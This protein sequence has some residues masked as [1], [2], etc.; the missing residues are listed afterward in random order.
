M[1]N[2][3]HPYSYAKPAITPGAGAATGEC[4]PKQVPRPGD[5]PDPGA[6]RIIDAIGEYLGS[7]RDPL[8]IVGGL[9]HVFVAAE[10]AWDAAVD[11]AKTWPDGS[12]RHTYRELTDAT[13]GLVIGTLQGRIHAH[14]RRVRAARAVTR[15]LR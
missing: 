12:R 8:V 5:Q 1:N 11:Q 7:D 9:L 15:R 13:G 3:T 2:P 10:H 4:V 6:Q 14:R